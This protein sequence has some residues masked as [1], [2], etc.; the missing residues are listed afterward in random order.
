MPQALWLPQRCFQMWI[1]LAKCRLWVTMM[2]TAPTIT[3]LM[4]SSK[5]EKKSSKTVI[6]KSK[7]TPDLDLSWHYQI[8]LLLITQLKVIY[9]KMSSFIW[10]SESIETMN[11]EITINYKL[12]EIQS[13]LYSRSIN[14]LQMIYSRLLVMMRNKSFKLLCRS[15]SMTVTSLNKM[16]IKSWRRWNG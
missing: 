10:R 7:L 3:S 15:I 1:L 5:S 6:P 9:L 8:E 4:I 14:F 2:R 11:F 12:E 13:I 16:V